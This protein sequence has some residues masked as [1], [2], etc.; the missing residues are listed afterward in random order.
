MRFGSAGSF[1][2]P[3]K[4]TAV[5]LPTVAGLSVRRPAF[6]SLRFIG[7]T[8]SAVGASELSPARPGLGN[9]YGSTSSTGGAT[10]VSQPIGFGGS[11][12][13]FGRPREPVLPI[14]R[15]RGAAYGRLVLIPSSRLTT[16]GHIETPS[17]CDTQRGRPSGGPAQRATFE[18]SE[19]LEQGPEVL[20][21]QSL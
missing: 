12:S 20:G 1:C 13:R 6:R 17:R 8:P 18:F 3:P 11:G 19:S 7:D 2:P 10:H 14:P 4:L 9:S 16:A 15:V 5:G 21:A